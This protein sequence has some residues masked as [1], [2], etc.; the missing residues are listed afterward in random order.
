MYSMVASIVM[1]EFYFALIGLNKF[2][3]ENKEQYENF[4]LHFGIHE[5]HWSAL[6]PI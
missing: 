5:S 6:I 4:H 2:S 3:I 1:Q